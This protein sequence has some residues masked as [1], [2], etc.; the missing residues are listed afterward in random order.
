MVS[1]PKQGV[2]RATISRMITRIISEHKLQ[3]ITIK[4]RNSKNGYATPYKIYGPQEVIQVTERR[5][6]R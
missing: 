1:L 2:A 5:S 4:R 3:E 6:A